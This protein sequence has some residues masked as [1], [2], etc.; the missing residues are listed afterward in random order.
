MVAPKHV[1]RAREAPTQPEVPMS[2]NFILAMGALLWGLAAFDALIHLT[3]GDLLTPAVMG[4]GAIVGVTWIT[5]R[6][7]RKGTPEGV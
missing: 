7:A 1:R 4:V 3:E 5:F 6:W 2:R